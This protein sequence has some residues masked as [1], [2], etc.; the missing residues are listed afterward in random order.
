MF[1]TT[2]SENKLSVCRKV[3]Y[4]ALKEFEEK[5]LTA[6]EKIK[7]L[8]KV[9]FEKIRLNISDQSSRIRKTASLIANIDVLCSLAE[10]ADTNGYT[11]P[12]VNDSNIINLKDSRHPV[13]E[14]LDLENGFVPNDILL[15]RDNQLLLITGPNMA[16][17]ST[18]IRQA[19]LVVIMAQ[20]E[21]FIPAANAEIG[22]IDKVFT[23]VGASDN[24]AKGLSTFMVEM[25]ETA[26]ILRNSTEKSFVILDE[27][28]R[29]TSTFDGM[30]IAWAVAEYLHD[31]GEKTLFATH[32]HELAQ[33]THST[34]G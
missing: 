21:S 7:E 6:E 13:V 11:R 32:Y 2:I 31:L 26:Y 23:R 22:I 20:I 25:V 3:Y 19:A 24:L 16:G 34:P 33:L 5:I 4:T 29:G 9:L 17:K 30:S 14:C 28:G 27:I 10:V 15:D 18:L 8:E 1:P 12:E